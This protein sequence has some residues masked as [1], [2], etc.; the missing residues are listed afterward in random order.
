MLGIGI[1]SGGSR[2]NFAIL[3]EG[4]RDAL[5]KSET[6]ASIS[7]ARSQDAIAHVGDWIVDMVDKQ[8]DDDICVWIGAAGFSASTSHA[9]GNRLAPSMRRLGQLMEEQGRHCEVFIANDA[10]AI[11]K[12]P[13][14]NGTGLVAV[15]GTGSVVIGTHPSYADGVIKR[16]GYEWLATDEGAGDWMTIQSIRYILKDILARGPKE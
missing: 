7:T 13:P 15:V 16:G 9:I 5:T 1:D 10:V 2:T 8:Q 14:L 4:A 11:L 6:G 12:A 3:Q